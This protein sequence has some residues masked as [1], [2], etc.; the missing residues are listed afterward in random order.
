MDDSER[1]ERRKEVKLVRERER[2]GEKVGRIEMKLEIRT[3]GTEVEIE[4]GGERDKVRDEEE[5]SMV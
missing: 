2:D 4:R 1:Q 3:I 5:E